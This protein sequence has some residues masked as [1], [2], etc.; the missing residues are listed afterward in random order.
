MRKFHLWQQLTFMLDRFLE[1]RQPAV[2]MVTLSQNRI[3]ILP[4]RLG[5]WFG[6]L[7]ILLYLLGTNYQNNLILITAFMLI[8]LFLV[9]MLQAFY[10]L[11]RLQLRVLSEPAAFAGENALVELELQ[12][13]SAQ[14]LQLSWFKQRS[15]YLVSQVEGKTTF[16]LSLSGFDRGCYPL[17]RLKIA[18]LYPFGLFRCWSYP[19]LAAKVWIYPAPSVYAATA[20]QLIEDNTITSTNQHGLEPDRIKNY[21]PGDLPA[22]ILWKKLAANPNL[23]V[24]RHAAPQ[25]NQIELWIEVPA[26][27]GK[28]LEE[29]LSAAAAKAIHLELSMLDYGLKLP[30][31]TVSPASGQ[32]HLTR[33]LQE[34]ALC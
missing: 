34:L 16:A 13:I 29:A 19:A 23:T 3:Y 32:A 2:A 6:L 7:V 15:S 4:S 26:L 31:L 8:S 17:P 25:S 27:M 10:N 21:Q 24:V 12:S 28:A 11:H 33:C 14:M 9:A 1:R 20:K 30:H 22:R 5:C 18:S